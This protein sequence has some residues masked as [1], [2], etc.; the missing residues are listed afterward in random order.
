VRYF[1]HARKNGK[2]NR[3]NRLT[4]SSSME[5]TKI[6]SSLREKERVFG[7]FFIWSRSGKEGGK[8]RIRRLGAWS[9]KERG[10]AE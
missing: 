10:E 4:A 6:R 3:W 9:W 8:R 1:V 7:F 2:R 5:T